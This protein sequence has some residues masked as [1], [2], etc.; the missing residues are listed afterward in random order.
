M[1][2]GPQE[3][4][5]RQQTIS[6]QELRVAGVTSDILRDWRDFYREE[7]Q[8]HPRNPSAAARAA[9]MEH[10]LYLLES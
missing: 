2:H 4:L 6:A 3:A 1:G 10:C 5:A 8:R 9:L 7:A